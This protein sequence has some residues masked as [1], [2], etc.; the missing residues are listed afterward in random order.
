M[1]AIAKALSDDM[2][3]YNDRLHD[4]VSLGDIDQEIVWKN[5]TRAQLRAAF[6][7]VE[8][9]DHWKNPINKTLHIL[10]EEQRT[11]ISEAIIFFAASKA[12]WTHIYGNLWNVKA[13]GYYAS[14]GA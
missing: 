3:A 12:T 1:A 9:E 6:E 8:N 4:I 13:D 11:L 7:M 2:T 5:F 10:T 14:V